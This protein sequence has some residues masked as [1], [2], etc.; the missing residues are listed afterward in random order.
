[1]TGRDNRQTT[2]LEEMDGILKTTGGVSTAK[3]HDDESS[4]PLQINKEGRFFIVH[5]LLLL[6]NAG[7][8]CLL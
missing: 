2:L 1:M 7:D 6:F 4:S 3:S 8:S 5:F